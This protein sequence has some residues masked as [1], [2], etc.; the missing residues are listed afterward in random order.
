MK[1]R[2]FLIIVLLFSLLSGCKEESQVTTPPEKQLMLKFKMWGGWAA[3]DVSLKVF[4]DNTAIKNDSN[5]E[6]E[7]TFSDAEMNHL[8]LLLNDFP[9]FSRIYKQPDIIYVDIYNFELIN[10]ENNIPDTVT[11][12]EPINKVPESLREIINVLS[13]KSY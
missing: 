5:A 13:N 7:V 12:Y 8:D 3:S 11:V 9:S 6:T 4:N 1:I 2:Y 10:Y